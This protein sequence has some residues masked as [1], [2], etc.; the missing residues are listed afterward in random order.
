MQLRLVDITSELSPTETG[1]LFYYLLVFVGRTY[2]WRPKVGHENF[3][4]K[5]D[6]IKAKCLFSKHKMK[7]LSLWLT[8]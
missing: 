6:K 8:S 1:D 4:N 7:A 5:C 3:K 2:F